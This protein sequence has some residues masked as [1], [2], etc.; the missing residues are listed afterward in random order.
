M[1]WFMLLLPL[2]MLYHQCP[3][4]FSQVMDVMHGYEATVFAYGQTGTGKV[5]E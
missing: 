2:C 4:V 5:M 3:C 1:L